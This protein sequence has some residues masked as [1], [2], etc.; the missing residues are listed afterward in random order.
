MSNVSKCCSKTCF[1]RFSSLSL[2]SFFNIVFLPWLVTRSPIHG[3]SI[4]SSRNAGPPFN[5][6][7]TDTTC[8]QP[9]L[10]ILL[11]TSVHSLFR[12]SSFHE[13]IY[14]PGRN[15]PVSS[16]LAPY[17]IFLSFLENL[18]KNVINSFNKII[19]YTNFLCN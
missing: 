11:P 8:A 10:A 2:Q 15:Y 13:S 17:Y 3:F 4:H 16:I 6:F 7:S 18:N 9:H 1:L 14:F 5:L 19:N 12:E